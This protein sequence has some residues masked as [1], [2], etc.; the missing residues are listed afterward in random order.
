MAMVSS[1]AHLSHPAH[2]IDQRKAGAIMQT[3][4]LVVIVYSALSGKPV[5][6]PSGIT[7][8]AGYTSAEACEAAG[9]A[10]IQKDASDW[11]DQ[12]FKRPLGEPDRFFVQIKPRCIPGPATK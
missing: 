8:I 12:D 2:G 11:V 9:A 3:W 5:L 7:S 4:V 6:G 1:L 10:L